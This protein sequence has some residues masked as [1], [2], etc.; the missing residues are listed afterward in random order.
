MLFGKCLKKPAKRKY[1]QFRSVYYNA[2]DFMR[3]NSDR[4]GL[5]LCL[6]R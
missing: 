5:K 2:I 3:L 1:T 6:M 4:T